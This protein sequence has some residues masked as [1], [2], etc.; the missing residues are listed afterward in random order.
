MDDTAAVVTSAKMAHSLFADREWFETWIETFGQE[1]SGIWSAGDGSCQIAYA[2]GMKQRYGV[3]ALRI[4]STG[5]V[6][7]DA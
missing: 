3:R 6:D 4:C 1:R 7:T 5:D 2:L